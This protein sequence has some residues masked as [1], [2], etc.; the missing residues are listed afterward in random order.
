MEAT[1]VGG[2]A[3]ASWRWTGA[4]RA[5]SALRGRL[6]TKVV[7]YIPAEVLAAYLFMAGFIDSNVTSKHDHAIWLGGLLVG[8][9][10]LTIPMISGFSS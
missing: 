1:P 6:L 10:V 5:G 9:L 3:A 8:I 4:G 7:K 2:A